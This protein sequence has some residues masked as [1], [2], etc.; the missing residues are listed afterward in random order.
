[1]S[2]QD[3]NS[4]SRRKMIFKGLRYVAVGLLGVTAAGQI[5]KRRRLVK[6]GKCENRGI[7][8]GCG[9][10]DQCQLPQALSRKQVLAE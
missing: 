5:S 10:Y 8:A 6:E 2:R 1:M 4:K 7:C 3:I 9:V